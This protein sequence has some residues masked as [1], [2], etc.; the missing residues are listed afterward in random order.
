MPAGWK[1]SVTNNINNN[2]LELPGDNVMKTMLM[3]RM[4]KTTVTA[5]LGTALFVGAAI[6]DAAD[7][8][9]GANNFY[10]SEKVNVETVKFN[11]M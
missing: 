3:D 6:A 4:K 1:R 9:R 2:E 11:N 7:M 8:S 10:T 5:V